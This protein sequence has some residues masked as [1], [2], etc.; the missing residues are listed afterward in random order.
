MRSTQSLPI[1]LVAGL[2][3]C[4]DLTRPTEAGD[5]PPHA[6]LVPGA[7]WQVLSISS[8]DNGARATAIN[9][10]GAIVGH[11]VDDQ[12]VSRAFRHAAGSMTI[13]PTAP[14]TEMS[15]FG[16]NEGGQIAGATLVNGTMRGY[17]RHANGV[18]ALLPHFGQAGTNNFAFAINDL[19][20]VA[21]HTDSY[22]GLRWSVA[23]GG[24][25][26][27]PMPIVLSRPVMH[28]QEINNAG[29]IVGGVSDQYGRS[30]A[31]VQQPG[32]PV[33]LIGS[34]GNR[35]TGWSINNSGK[36]LGASNV[37]GGDPRY[38]SWTSFGGI[39]NEAGT[40]GWADRGAISDKGRIAGVDNINGRER[41]FTVYQG[42]YDVLPLL[43]NG[44]H[45]RAYAVNSCGTIVG[46]VHTSDGFIHAVRWRRVV[47]NPP[48][49]IC[50]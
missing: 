6:A 29:W 10:A 48:V 11:R 40:G 33:Q 7:Y 17:V 16:I 3:G 37:I 4:A 42:I 8:S 18:V 43:P 26:V 27:S 14:G 34:L 46:T 45:S 36:V 50:D 24:W 47:G 15:A 31:F 41:A 2:L 39:K 28:V 44:R 30:E 20:E 1:A 21:G 22:R 32:G 12:G 19:G 9:D 25:T 49:G 5:A 23:F 13:F 38:F 35:S